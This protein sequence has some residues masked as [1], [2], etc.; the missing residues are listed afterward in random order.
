M[1]CGK[2]TVTGMLAVAGFHCIDTD[3]LVRDRVLD[4]PAVKSALRGHFGGEVFTADGRVDRKALAGLVFADDA[5]RLWLEALIHPRVFAIWRSTL[6]TEPAARW[7]VEAPLLFEKQLENW[8]DFTVCV[9]SAP[10]QQLARLERR[11]LTR[12][13]ARQRISKQ[14]PLAQK[15]ELSD[16]VLWNDGP[17]SFLQRQVDRLVAGLPAGR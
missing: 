5:A 17:I 15:T 11:G 12:T 10:E 9:A 2:S 7:A 1:G 4:D 16:M 3:A 13:L 14:L 8:F 6:Q